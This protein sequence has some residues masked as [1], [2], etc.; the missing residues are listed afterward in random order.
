MVRGCKFVLQNNFF[1][2]YYIYIY[3]YIIFG[4]GGSFEPPNYNILPPLGRSRMS[5]V[6][7]ETRVQV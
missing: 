1:K 4:S 6:F 3:L 7:Q 5:L 2:K